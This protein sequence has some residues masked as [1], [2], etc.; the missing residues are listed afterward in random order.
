VTVRTNAG[1]YALILASVV[2]SACGQLLMKLGTATLPDVGIARTLSAALGEPMVLLGVAS[3]ALS[4]V[5]W[6]VILS[7]M[8]LSTAYPFAALSYVVV[9]GAAMLSGEAVTALR[10]AGVA[11]I[12][13]GVWLVAAG[14]EG[15]EE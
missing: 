9:V 15:A 1:D 12:V 3:Y 14:A 4:S 7:R 2:L 10:W 5:V 13:A 8:P 11:F 6:L